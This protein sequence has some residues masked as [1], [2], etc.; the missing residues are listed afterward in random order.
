LFRRSVTNE[1]IAR[2][3]MVDFQRALRGIQGV[4][5]ARVVINETSSVDENGMP[6]N[7]ISAAV[8]GGEDLNVGEVVNRY[9]TPG[10]ST[11]GNFSILTDENGFCRQFR[12]VRPV[13]VP[14][15]LVIDV[16]MRSGDCP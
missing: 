5:W 1:G 11:H 14:V 7:T 2:V 10:I 4:E 16:R 15:K 3:G 9:V 12:I 6:P 8:I 13:E